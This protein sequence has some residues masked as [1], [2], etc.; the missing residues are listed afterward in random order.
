MLNGLLGLD[1]TAAALA[2][3]AAGAEMDADMAE[4]LAAMSSM[5]MSMM[6]DMQARSKALEEYSRAAAAAGLSEAA[7]SATISKEP[8]ETSPSTGSKQSRRS[9]TVTKPHNS[10]DDEMPEDLSIKPRGDGDSASLPLSAEGRL[11]RESD[12][13]EGRKSNQSEGTDERT[14][15]AAASD[16]LPSADNELEN[17]SPEPEDV[18]KHPERDACESP[19][20][21]SVSQLSTEGQNNQPRPES[22][23]SLS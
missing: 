20:P 1:P 17:N 2:A 10:S 8:G 16:Q 18:K 14:V 3:G 23:D 5:S 4:K 11:S 7:T 13:A 21:A 12:I 19:G 6:E 15:A 22:R 9:A